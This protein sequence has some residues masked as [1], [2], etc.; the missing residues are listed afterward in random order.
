MRQVTAL[1]I[2]F[3]RFSAISAYQSRDPGEGVLLPACLGRA[4]SVREGC[5]KL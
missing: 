4:E 2:I 3:Q 1:K 5:G